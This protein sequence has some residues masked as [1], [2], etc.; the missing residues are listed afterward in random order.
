MRTNQVARKLGTLVLTYGDRDEPTEADW[1]ALLALLAVPPSELAKLKIL[2]VTN[3]SSPNA[4]QRQRLKVAL[5][6]V[7]FRAAIV[8]DS[9]PVRF[10]VSMI[11]LFHRD[12]RSFATSELEQAYDHLQMTPAERRLS[13]TTLVE[14]K[15]QVD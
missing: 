3:G 11:A 7:R 15:S 6:G 8:S 12:N 4:H 2:I 1:D 9:I 5:G 13:Q 14:M 10:V